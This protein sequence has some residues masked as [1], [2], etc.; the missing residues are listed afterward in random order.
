MQYSYNWGDGSSSSVPIAV[1]KEN[2]TDIN[3]DGDANGYYIAIKHSGTYGSDSYTDWQIMY[4]NSKGVIAV[5]YT[6][7]R[8]HET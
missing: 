7:L 3:S 4:T 1:E 6:H 2:G 8:A 5:S